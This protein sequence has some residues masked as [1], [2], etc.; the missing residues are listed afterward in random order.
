MLWIFINGS[1]KMTCRKT[2]TAHFFE[3]GGFYYG[4]FFVQKLGLDTA[5][6]GR[7][8]TEEFFEIGG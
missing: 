3:S 4:S 1:H 7:E 2:E 5:G 8:K 6:K